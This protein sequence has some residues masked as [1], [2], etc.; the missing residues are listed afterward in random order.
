MPKTRSKRRTRK[1]KKLSLKN[2]AQALAKL[3]SRQ[4]EERDRDIA[5]LERA[6]RK[7]LKRLRPA[8]RR[9]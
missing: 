9:R 4:E 7:K 1:T 3:I 6:I 8:K 5:Q 2:A